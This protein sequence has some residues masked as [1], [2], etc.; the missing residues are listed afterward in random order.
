M[1]P[2][3]ALA[4]IA[5][6]GS[7]IFA[8]DEATNTTLSEEAIESAPIISVSN[9]TT[10]IVVVDESGGNS[11]AALLARDLNV[12]PSHHD[13]DICWITNLK[14]KGPSPPH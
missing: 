7:G 13:I 1:H 12:N 5:L 9:V 10:G 2:F 14:K 11:S 8:Q 3:V 4:S 6:L